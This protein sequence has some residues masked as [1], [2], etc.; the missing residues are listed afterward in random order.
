M[1]TTKTDLFYDDLM[2]VL[3]KHGI[4]EGKY[5]DTLLGDAIKDLVDAVDAVLTKAGG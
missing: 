4:A 2:D 1:A 5:K 3:E